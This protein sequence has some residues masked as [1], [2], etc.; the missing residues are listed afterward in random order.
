MMSTVRYFK[1]VTLSKLAQNHRTIQFDIK[2]L[3]QQSSGIFKSNRNLV[4]AVAS[5]VVAASA[6]F[7]HGHLK[8][9]DS[10]ERTI[11]LLNPLNLL[12]RGYTITLVDGK[13]LKTVKEAIE[14]SLLQTILPDGKIISK[15]QS[16]NKTVNDE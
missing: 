3:R 13:P 16:V 10:I 4:G 14:G 11:E 2:T 12:K 5:A 1:S 8:D 6:A 9:I 15:I 7:I